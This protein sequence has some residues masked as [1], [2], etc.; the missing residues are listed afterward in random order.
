MGGKGHM[1]MNDMAR[2]ALQNRGPVNANR[3]SFHFTSG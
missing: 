2:H 3:A 1:V